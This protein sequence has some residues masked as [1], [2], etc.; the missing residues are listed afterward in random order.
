MADFPT[1]ILRPSVL[2]DL[3]PE[4]PAIR[5]EMENG[6]VQSRARFTRVRKSWT[7]SWTIIK[8]ADYQTVRAHWDTQK[9]GSDAFQWTNYT[10]GKTYNVRYR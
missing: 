2:R 3:S 4:D 9:G 10:N 5:T 6:M 7:L 8:E 1:N